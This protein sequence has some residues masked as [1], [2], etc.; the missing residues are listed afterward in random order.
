[1]AIVS[2]LCFALSWRGMA[3]QHQTQALTPDVPCSLCVSSNT[4]LSSRSSSTLV[5]SV[6]SSSSWCDLTNLNQVKAY[7]MKSALSASWTCG[8]CR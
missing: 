2:V 8:A 3:W 6:S 7:P 5:N 1:M 4:V